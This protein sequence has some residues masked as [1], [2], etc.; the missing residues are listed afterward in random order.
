MVE[1][2]SY[3]LRDFTLLGVTLQYWQVLFAFIIALWILYLFIM[4]PFQ[5]R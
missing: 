5:K 4:S 1:F 2:M 3:F